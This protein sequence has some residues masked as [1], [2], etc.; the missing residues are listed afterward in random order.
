M[1]VSAFFLC[2]VSK[3]GSPDSSGAQ[4]T[5]FYGGQVIVLNDLPADKAKEVI[6]LATGLELSVKKRKVETANSVP[7]S[8]VPA[9]VPVPAPNADQTQNLNVVPNLRTSVIP[10]TVSQPSVP[11]VSGNCPTVLNF[12]VF[13]MVYVR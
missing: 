1:K 5:I 13:A 10:T 12:V 11:N 8:P 7:A 6:D 2:S 4:M 9:P 3:P